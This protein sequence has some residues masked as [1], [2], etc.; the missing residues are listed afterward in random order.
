MVDISTWYKCYDSGWNGLIVPEA[1]AHPAKF[2]RSLI[3]RIYQHCTAEGWLAPGSTVLD[4]FAGTGLGG[5]DAGLAGYRFIGVELEAR[6]CALAHGFDCD[7]QVAQV[8]R[9]TFT[10]AIPARH[11]WFIT[12]GVDLWGPG[13]L[14]EGDGQGA[15]G[16]ATASAAQ[17]WME[18]H[19]E[20]FTT[21]WETHSGTMTMPDP[22]EI[23]DRGTPGTCAYLTFAWQIVTPA[24][25]GQKEPHEP[26]HVTGNLELWQRRYGHLPQYVAPTLLQGDSRMLGTVLREQ[27]SAC[28]SSPPFQQSLQ[29]SA[30]ID[31]ERRRH[32]AAMLGKP[33]AEVSPLDMAEPA[34]TSYGTSPGQ[35]GAL[36]PGSL[37]A[38][39]SSPPHMHGL[40]KEHTYADHAKRDHDSHRAIMREKGIADPYYGSDPAQLGN[41][42]A[43][44]VECAISSPPYEASVTTG[45]APEKDIARAVAAG[46]TL[47]SMGNP[48]GQL[49]YAFEYGA[50]PAQ[51]GNEHGTTFWEAARDIVK[52]VV[53]LLKPN[54]I[55]VFVVKAYVRDGA[56]VDFPGQWRTLCESLGLVTLH[57]HHALLVEDHGTQHDLLQ[58]DTPDRKPTSTL[59]DMLKP[60]VST[61]TYAVTNQAKRRQTKRVSFF[62]RL[63]EKRRPDLAIEYEVVLCMQKREGTTAGSVEVCV[64]SPPW[65][66]QEPSHAQSDTPSSRRL[67]AEPAATRGQA[68][69]DA[70]YGHTE[71]QLGSMPPGRLDLCLSSPPYAEVLCGA[72][73]M[74][75]KDRQH[76]AARGR[77][78][79]TPGSGYPRHYGTTPGN[80]GHLPEGLTPAAGD[81]PCDPA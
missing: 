73:N 36:P 68:F 35:L 45:H 64:S 66:D 20:E 63:H 58:P 55:A 69:L 81:A 21:T 24:P 77:N 4:C 3:Q 67:R 62:R 51:L 56:I 49:R 1:Y 27:V 2:S 18:R 12:D 9:S 52:Q 39:I 30:G 22:P 6:F 80:L 33:Q 10:P 79:D 74:D 70:T 40:G 41:L 50:D 72:T 61:S 76:T 8:L 37:D 44:T 11:A 78:P 43:G 65:Q 71:G 5:L 32:V 13:G 31:L 16:F 14:L 59:D 75:A 17:A 7:G 23:V 46:H 54:G 34:Q 15:A 42:P 26:H 47:A 57:E 48:G 25:C 19:P 28:V 29:A 38:A 60:L 53:A